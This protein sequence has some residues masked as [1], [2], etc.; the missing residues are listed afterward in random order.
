MVTSARERVAALWDA[1]IAAWLNG[2]DR[3]PPWLEGWFDSYVGVGAGEVTRDGFPEPYHGDLLGLEHTPRMVVLGLNPGA[4]HSRFQ[5]RDGIFAEEI[6]RHFSYSRWATTCPYNRP[7]WTLPHEMGDNKYYKAR[8]EFTRRWLQDPGADHRDL[9]IFECYPWHSTSINAPLKP[10]PEVIDEFVWQPVAELPVQDVFAFGRPW[11][12]LAQVLGLRETSRLGSGGPDY[13]SSVAS[14][15]VRVYALPS[16]QRLVVE[17]HAGSAGPPSAME[18]ALLRHELLGAT[19]DEKGE[20]ST[21]R[22]RTEA[23]RASA[24]AQT[25]AEPPL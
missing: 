24:L 6:R 10:P 21:P 13:G 25:S 15:A 2:D 18:T 5:G 9:L 17:W 22:P 14:R 20:A 12:D 11:D 1:H 3:L 7:P 8:L 19:D 16:G 4:F 23:S